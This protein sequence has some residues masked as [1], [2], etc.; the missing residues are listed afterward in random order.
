M[1]VTHY[2]GP[3]AL[4]PVGDPMARELV[5]KLPAVTAIEDWRVT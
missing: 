3:Q 4:F 5:P 1:G 2:S